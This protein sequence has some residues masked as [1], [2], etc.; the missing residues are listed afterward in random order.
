MPSSSPAAR[1]WP[2]IAFVEKERAKGGT[3][4]G[5]PEGL[6][7][8]KPYSS[9][10]ERFARVEAMLGAGGEDKEKWQRE[11]K[12]KKLDRLHAGVGCGELDEAYEPTS[13]SAA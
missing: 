12:E 8:Q 6:T 13:Y 9:E 11:V 5:A 3:A 2:S 4:M 10:E 1:A 7:F